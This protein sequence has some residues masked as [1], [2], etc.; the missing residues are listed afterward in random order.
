MPQSTVEMAKQ[1]TMAL[2]ETRSIPPERMQET[3]QQTYAMLT[4]L[5]V[6]EESGAPAP[7]FLSETPPGD[8]RKSITKHAVTCL[9]CGQTFKQLTIRHL[10]QH[11]LDARSYRTKHSIPRTQT[12]AA[13]ATTARRREVVQETRPW[14]KA[15]TFRKEQAQ[16]GNAAPEPDAEAVPDE[17]D[18]PT[19]AAASAQPKRQRKTSPKKTGR[20]TRSEG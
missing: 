9:E 6:Q 17:T 12:L 2:I 16:D 18:A 15:P 3:L 10:R 13:R 11:G 8:W 20:K 19:T 7:N 5:K 1:L 14:E 4:T